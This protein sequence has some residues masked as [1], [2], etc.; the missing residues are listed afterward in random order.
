MQTCAHAHTH[1]H[2]RPA[3]DIF[4]VSRVDRNVAFKAAGFHGNYF[5]SMD[6]TMS[7]KPVT[8]MRAFLPLSALTHT[9]GTHLRGEITSELCRPRSEE[10]LSAI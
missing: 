10:V 7:L 3:A 6:L 5:A 1:T 2:E 9:E 4:A 8:I